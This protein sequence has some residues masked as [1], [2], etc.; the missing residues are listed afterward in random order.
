MVAGPVTTRMM[1]SQRF[2]GV[3]SLEGTCR[4]VF[5]V[6]FLVSSWPNDGTLELYP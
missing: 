5:G 6:G 2:A 4:L 1:S 3:Y